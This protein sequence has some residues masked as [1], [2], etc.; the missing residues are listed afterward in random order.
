MS[1]ASTTSRA[2]PQDARPAAIELTDVIR[3]FREVDV[4]TVALRGV[5]LRIGAGEL[6]AIMG[7]SGSGK[8]T[9]LHLIAG[10]D[11]PTAGRVEVEGVD[12]GRAEEAERARI[13]GARVGIVFQRENL[14]PFLTVRE[15]IDLITRLAGRTLDHGAIDDLLRRVGLDARADHRPSQLSGGEQQRAA[16][17]AVVATRA[18]IVLGD[19][20]TGELDTAN[21]G[22]LLD[23]LLDLHAA[24]GI[25]VV[26]AT[27]DP[28]VAA[29]AG[30]VVQLRDGRIVE[31]G[32][33]S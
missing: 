4:E 32:R 7:R 23:L 31:D 17:A 28:A 6:V 22:L 30:R 12:L 15:N 18:P 11:R 33:P 20:I 29:R 10:S 14:V 21:A 25:T 5:S 19:E 26:L 2:A 24:E 9:L 8:S 27:H 1:A 13:R 3:V 16:L